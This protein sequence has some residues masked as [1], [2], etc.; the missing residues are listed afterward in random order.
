MTAYDVC[1]VGSGPAA[2]TCAIYTARARLSTVLFEGWMAGGIAAGGQLTT[3]SV[4]ENFPGFPGGINGA[5]LCRLFR[6]Q[7]AEMG[8]KILTETVLSVEKR[9]D[10]FIVSTD[11]MVVECRAV[12]I[13]T[14]ATAKR[15]GVEGEDTFWNAGISACAVCDGAA[16]IFRNKPIA[17]VG[18]GDSAM[19]EAL[20]LTKYASV[21]YLIHRSA[22]F[23]ASKIM[24]T[25][26]LEHPKIRVML[27]KEVKGAYGDD[28]L[29]EIEL[30]DTQTGER[31]RVQV[32]GLFYAI[33]H[34]PASDFVKDLVEI[35]D[36]GYIVTR[37]GSTQ[38]S[39]PGVFAAGDVQ[40]RRWRQA[41]TA[42]GSGCMAA[43]EVEEYLSNV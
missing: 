12:V 41:I 32:S 43:L 30:E 29:R 42:A 33:G 25:R 6:E 27:Y 19:E 2:H 17:V 10:V 24:Q 3:T 21:V 37:P 20:Y 22:T 16:P 5:D 26:A 36:T 15:L 38:T 7:S 8:T 28:L 31:S 1:I 11:T 14:G 35:D 40:D 9:S 18:G 4:V 23:R 39:V 34:K 13:A